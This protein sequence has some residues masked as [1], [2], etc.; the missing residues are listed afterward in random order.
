MHHHWDNSH[1]QESLSAKDVSR[2][3]GQQDKHIDRVS[4]I[5]DTQARREI[6]V[7]ISETNNVILNYC[8]WAVP[9]R[10]VQ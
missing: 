7:H 9:S 5:P 3:G 10:C 8:S 4:I 2:A 6:T 1:T